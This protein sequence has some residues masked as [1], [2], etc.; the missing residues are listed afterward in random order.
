MVSGRIVVANARITE[1]AKY[2][3]EKNTKYAANSHSARKKYVSCP[4]TLFAG[5]ARK[6]LAA[7]KAPIM[8]PTA[9]PVEFQDIIISKEAD[10]ISDRVLI[11]RDKAGITSLKS[12]LLLLAD[13]KNLFTIVIDFDITPNSTA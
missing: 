11:T 5:P 12:R 10:K 13:P 7:I 3:P 4:T 9:I 8:L 1:P 2:L 6:R